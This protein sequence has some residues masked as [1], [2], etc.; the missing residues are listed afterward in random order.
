MSN[1]TLSVAYVADFTLSFALT[2]S[3]STTTSSSGSWYPLGQ[4]LASYTTWQVVNGLKY[5]VLNIKVLSALTT[6]LLLTYTFNGTTQK[7]SLDVN[8]F[9]ASLQNPSKLQ[10]SITFSAGD[11]IEFI[12]YPTSSVTTAATE[13]ITL[14]ILVEPLPAK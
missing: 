13:T 14:S 12:A 5:S 9:D 10:Q 2:A 8:Y 1:Q 3:Q 4:S 7:T 6:D 11:S